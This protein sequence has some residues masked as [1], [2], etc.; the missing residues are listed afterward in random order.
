MAQ[1]GDLLI[2]EGGDVAETLGRQTLQRPLWLQ[3][4]E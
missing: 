3:Q 2:C 1:K 4:E